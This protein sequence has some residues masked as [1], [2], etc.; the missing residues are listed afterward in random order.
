MWTKTRWREIGC[1][2]H[3]DVKSHTYNIYLAVFAL[4]PSQDKRRNTRCLLLLVC[5]NVAELLPAAWSSLVYCPPP[6]VPCTGGGGTL[7]TRW[8]VAWTLNPGPLP[9]PPRPTTQSLIRQLGSIKFKL[10][11]HSQARNYQI[12]VSSTRQRNVVVIFTIF[13]DGR[14]APSPVNTF[15]SETTYT[16][17]KENIKTV[18]SLYT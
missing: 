12:K 1:Y 2:L 17:A 5:R 16:A 8:T 4:F 18:V 3:R 15:N 10:H 14:P 11:K 7:S 6:G 9:W 13:G